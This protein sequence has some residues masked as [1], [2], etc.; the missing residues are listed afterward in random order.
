MAKY[1]VVAE[2]AVIEGRRFPVGTEL[3]LEVAEAEPY[4]ASGVLEADGEAVGAPEP[5]PAGESGADEGGEVGEGVAAA[6]PDVGGNPSATA[7]G[8]WVGGHRV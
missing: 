2:D 6:T 8:G 1:R 5:G 3:I 7:G 4:V